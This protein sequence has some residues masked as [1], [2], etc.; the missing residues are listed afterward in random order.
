M[1]KTNKPD[2][3]R[4]GGRGRSEV[5]AKHRM[6]KPAATGPQGSTLVTPRALDISPPFGDLLAEPTPPFRQGQ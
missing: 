5:T 3:A 2:A 4:G 1:D 6:E